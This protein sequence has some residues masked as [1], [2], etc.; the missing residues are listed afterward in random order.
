MDILELI[1][2]F[3]TEIQDF[4]YLIYDYLVNSNK[5]GK[6]EILIFLKKKIN[7]KIEKV[8]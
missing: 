2:Q 7:K 3:K 6:N 8:F 1:D 5:K 4:L